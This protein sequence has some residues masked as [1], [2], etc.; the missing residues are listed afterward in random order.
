MSTEINKVE[1]R[2]K[3]D[4]KLKFWYFEKTHQQNRKLNSEFSQHHM[5]S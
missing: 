4:N 5:A 2:K 3:V 1:N